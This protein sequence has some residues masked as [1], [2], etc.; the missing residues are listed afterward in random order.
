LVE[1][2]K[3]WDDLDPERIVGG[4]QLWIRVQA[5]ID[6]LPAGQRA[7]ILLR[8]MEGR[9]ATETCAL[10]D[11]SAEN[12]RSCCTARALPDPPGNR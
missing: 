2:P 3:L 5:V 8:D 7:V 6:T 4:Q 11:I 12:Q 1:A 9:D 10:L